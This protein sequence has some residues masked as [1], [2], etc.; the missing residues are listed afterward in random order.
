MGKIILKM[1]FFYKEKKN[2]KWEIV[3][4]CGICYKSMVIL[5]NKS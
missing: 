2:I 3:N 4:Y 1:I 5:K